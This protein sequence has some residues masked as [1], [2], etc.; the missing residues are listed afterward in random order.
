MSDMPDNGEKIGQVE[1]ARASLQQGETS[2]DQR[3]QLLNERE[4]SL[5]RL[6]KLNEQS[7]DQS[8]TEEQRQEAKLSYAQQLREGSKIEEKITRFNKTAAGSQLPIEQSFLEVA[9]TAPIEYKDDYN[10]YLENLLAEPVAEEPVAEAPAAEAPVALVPVAEAEAE[11]VEPVAVA[12]VAEAPVEEAEAPVAEAP[13]AES[14][15]PAAAEAEAPVALVPVAEAEAE[16][17]P[18]KAAQVEDLIAQLNKLEELLKTNPTED[19]IQERFGLLNELNRLDKNWVLHKSSK[20]N[21]YWNHQKIVP[22]VVSLGNSLLG[23]LIRAP[24]PPSPS[25]SP[26]PP[27]P[28]PSPPPSLPPTPP[29]KPPDAPPA[30]VAP[31]PAAAAAEEEAEAAARAA[32]AEAAR[33]AAEAE[34]ARA[35]AEAEAARAEAARAEAAARAAVAPAPADAPPAD[36]PPPPVASPPPPKPLPPLPLPPPPPPRPTRALALLPTGANQD[37]SKDLKGLLDSFRQKPIFIKMNIKNILTYIDNNIDNN[38]NTIIKTE[39][40]IIDY[41]IKPYDITI[42][43]KPTENISIGIWN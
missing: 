15:E 2:L 25:P 42:K 13:V 38:I 30:V 4:E 26:P 10:G 20:Q 43:Q 40:P 27:P 16:A 21:N 11:P 31:A 3:T 7:Q 8:L 14:A 24:P 36:A 28:P 6:K 1:A 33:A 12:P 23:T 19:L 35:A 32:E 5:E 41:T 22:R 18:A 9:N 17:E 29:P 37:M 34:A 39:T